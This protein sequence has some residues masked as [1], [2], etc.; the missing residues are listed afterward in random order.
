MLNKVRDISIELNLIIEMFYD[1]TSIGLK[2]KQQLREHILKT[3]TNLNHFQKYFPD[4]IEY[5]FSNILRRYFSR[6]ASVLNARD[7]IRSIKEKIER[8]VF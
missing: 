1:K 5:G 3:Q 6:E 8:E 7:K 2:K 4:S